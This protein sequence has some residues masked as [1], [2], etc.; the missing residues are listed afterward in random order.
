MLGH[1]LVAGPYPGEQPF[2]GG[3]GIGQGLQGGER[4]GTDH[5][6]RLGRIEVASLVEEVDRVDVGDEPAGDVVSGVVGQ[7]FIGHGRAQ[8]RSP[9]ADVD[10]RGDPVTGV[11]CPL[12]R[13]DAL[14]HLTHAV[15]YLVDVA[16][17]VLPV[18]GQL[19]IPGHPEGHVEH[20]PVLGGVDAPA[21]EHGV[22]SPF[23]VGRPGHRH[24]GGHGLL[25]N[26]VLGVVEIE[27]G[28]AHRHPGPAFGIGVKQV[29]QAVLADLV[30]IAAE[31]TPLL[32]PGDVVHVGHAGLRS[33]GDQ[34]DPGF[35]VLFAPYCDR[36]GMIR[37]PGSGRVRWW[38]RWRARTPAPHPVRRQSGPSCSRRTAPWR[39]PWPGCGGPW[40]W[41][42]RHR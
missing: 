27:I 11:A 6:H 36:I 4:L 23:D 16:H 28:G 32:G 38:A 15:E 9:D 42:H 17:H 26:P 20:G 12:P 7:G 33:R 18:D 39:W 2:P 5:E 10:H 22:A 3:G 40:C 21:G 8:V 1:R 35:R 30:E 41:R 25:G 29:A 37:W 13:A 24:Q 31:E 14:G 19:S 34:T